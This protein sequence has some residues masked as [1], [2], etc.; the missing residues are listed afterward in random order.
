MGTCTICDLPIEGPRLAD[1]DSRLEFHPA[2]VAE[3]IPEDAVI[4]VVTALALVL[5]P[6]VLVWA[7]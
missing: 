1:R 2:C 5:V 7:G 4:A 6:T 3:R